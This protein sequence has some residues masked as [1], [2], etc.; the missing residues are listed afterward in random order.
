M[1]GIL[2]DSEDIVGVVLR[3]RK[4]VRTEGVKEDAH[5]ETSCWVIWKMCVKI[6]LR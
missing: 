4:Q 2:V 5:K 6:D 3:R 1:R